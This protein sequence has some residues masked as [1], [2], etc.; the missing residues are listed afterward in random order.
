MNK[1]IKPTKQPWTR[2]SH[3]L[4]GRVVKKDLRKSYDHQENCP[5][6]ELKAGQKC[7][8]QSCYYGSTFYRLN[9]TLENSPIERIYVYQSYLEKEQTWKDILDSN[10][11]DQRYL[12]YCIKSR[13]TGNYLL[14]NWKVLRPKGG[15]HE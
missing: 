12:F 15:K 2:K 1:T 3:E 4:I 6:S 10:Y 8:Q 11:I 13:K 7:P 5:Q 9:V 14:T